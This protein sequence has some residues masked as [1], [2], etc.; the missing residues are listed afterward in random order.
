MKSLELCCPELRV[1]IIFT[2]VTEDGFV[3]VNNGKDISLPA[4][5]LDGDPVKWFR[6]LK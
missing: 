2:L 5:F 4:P 3:M 6:R 1:G